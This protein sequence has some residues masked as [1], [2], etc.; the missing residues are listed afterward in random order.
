MALIGATVSALRGQPG[1]AMIGDW[2]LADVQGAGLATGLTALA[3]RLGLFDD[4]SPEVRAFVSEQRAQVASRVDRFRRLTPQVLSALGDAAIPAVAVKGARLIDGVWPWPECRPMSDIDLLVPPRYRAQ[5]SAV[6][7]RSG[8]ATHS[9][10]TYEDTMLAWGDGAPGRLDG[11]SV[12][13]NGRI[14]VHPGWIEFLHGYTV[15]G[16]DVERHSVVAAQ[17][18]A[19]TREAVAAHVIGHLASTVVRAEVRAVNAIDVWF[20]AG[21]ELDWGAVAG[22]MSTVDPRLTAAGLWVVDQLIPDLVPPIVLESE[23][24]R[25]PRRGR[26]RLLRT[27]ALD[28]M[29]DPSQRTTVAWR[30]AFTTTRSERVAVV[31]QMVRRPGG[32]TPAAVRAWWTRQAARR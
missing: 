18:R 12:E 14:E 25:L 23:L 9:T 26:D 2:P 22:V 20:L 19:L 7:A 8:W 4:A 16:F 31:R 3:G 32:R 17:G 13:H 5:A 27:R 21:F 10:T 24:R 29:R 15:T 30:L 1:P 28:V 6:L 11:E